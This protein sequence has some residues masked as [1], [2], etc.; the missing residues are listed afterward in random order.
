MINRICPI[1]RKQFQIA[2]ARI[3]QGGGIYCSHICKG[4]AKWQ[5]GRL[6]ALARYRKNHPQENRIYRLTYNRN[7]R[8]TVKGHL[9]LTFHKMQERCN[10]QDCHNYKWYG[11]R[12]I[13]CKFKSSQEFV[14]YVVNN[15]QVDPRGVDVDRINNN[16]HYE[17][18][19]IR[20]ITHKENLQNCRKRRSYKNR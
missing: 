20:F 6:A 18:D 3:N 5:G 7:Y 17:P 15:L 12:G 4:K 10:R 14:N 11:G 2:I 8:K 16:G 9:V 19:N 13:Q 1:C